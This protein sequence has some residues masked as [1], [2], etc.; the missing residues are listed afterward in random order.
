VF[1]K[2]SP[3]AGKIIAPSMLMNVPQLVTAYFTGNRLRRF[4]RC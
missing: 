1:R 4:R 2:V 3:L